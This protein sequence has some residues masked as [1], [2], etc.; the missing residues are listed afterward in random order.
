M[1]A[2]MT[3]GAGAKL[4]MFGKKMPMPMPAAATPSKPPMKVAAIKVKGKK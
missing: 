4:P 2:K 3:K 1:G